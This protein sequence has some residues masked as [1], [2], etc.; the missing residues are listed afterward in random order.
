MPTPDINSNYYITTGYGGWSPCIEGNNQ[1][2]LRPFPGSV[3]PNCSGYATGRFNEIIGEGAC[4]YLGN[5]NG[6]DFMQFAGLQGLDTGTDPQP[7]CAIVWKNSGDGHVAIVEQVIDANT[8][9]ISQSG[10]DYTAAPIVRTVTRT[11][12]GGRWH[13]DPDYIFQ[14]CIYLPLDN[15]I[16]IMFG[17]WR[18][19]ED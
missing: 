2:N 19:E 8:I 12:Y 18:N 10:W 9:V 4:T 15:I 17:F 11:K 7:G 14:G 1:Y 6:G 16:S 13:P 3:L 5:A